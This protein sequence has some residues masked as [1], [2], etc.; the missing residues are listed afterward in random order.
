M[1]TSSDHDHEAFL[2]SN[3]LLIQLKSKVMYMLAQVQIIFPWI[4]GHHLKIFLLI[5]FVVICLYV[6][7]T[8]A[9]KGRS[10]KHTSEERGL[11]VEVGKSTFSKSDQVLYL[12]VL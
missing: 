11:K 3:S 8:K 1:D 6:D 12:D 5:R 7:T 2:N 10:Y 4:F 9:K